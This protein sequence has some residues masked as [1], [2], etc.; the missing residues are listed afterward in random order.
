MLQIPLDI[1]LDDSAHFSNY[2]AG[3]NKQLFDRLHSDRIFDESFIFIWGVPNSGKSHLAQAACRKYAEKGLSAYYFPLNTP[4]LSPQVLDGLEAADLVCLDNLESI[5]DSDEWERALFNLFNN[6]KNS[7]HNLILVG[8]YSANNIPIKLPDLASRLNSM[9][10]YRLNAVSDDEFVEFV[11]HNGQSRGLS[12]S[13]EIA[14][15]LLARANRDTSKLVSL[16]KALD[17]QSLAH[18]RKI[19]IPFVK[20]VL[21]L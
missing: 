17:Q 11:V 16:I 19:T 13:V 21:S 9:E 20:Q 15:F 3:K 7:Q 2:F 14:Q 4:S 6:L 10:V 18:Q 5:L 12:I 1:T 8:Q